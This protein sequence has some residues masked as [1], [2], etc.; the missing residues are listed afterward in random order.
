[1]MTLPLPVS[2]ASIRTDLPPGDTIKIESPSIGP[3]SSTWTWSSP[4]DAGGGLNFQRGQTYFHPTSPV[5]PSTITKIAIT[6]PQPFNDRF[7]KI[8]PLD[9]ELAIQ[10]GV[11]FKAYPSAPT[12]S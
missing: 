4:P 10:R 5:A 1:M 9:L 2:P 3:T 6:H 7:A 11:F 12:A 8:R